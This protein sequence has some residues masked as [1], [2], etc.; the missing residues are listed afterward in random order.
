MKN[1]QL[2]TASVA[3]KL[4]NVSVIIRSKITHTAA[5]Q[6]VALM[7]DVLMGNANAL[8]QG[9]IQTVSGPVIKLARRE[10]NV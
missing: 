3:Q 9:N 1:V 10:K 2:K 5:I 4:V 7:A 6:A 8:D